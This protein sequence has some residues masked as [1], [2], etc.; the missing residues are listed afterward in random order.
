[1][2][3]LPDKYEVPQKA[4]SYMKFQTGENRFRTLAS[5]IIGWEWWEEK[6][7]GS[8]KPVRVTMDTQIPVDAVEDPAT[9]KH[10]WAMPVYNYKEGKIQILEITQ[11]GIQKKIKSLAR[12]DDWGTPLGYDLVVIKTGEKLETEY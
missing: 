2:D 9:I 1:M 7:D 11:K 12:D 3:F 6:Q 4:G 10:F 8:R 5:P